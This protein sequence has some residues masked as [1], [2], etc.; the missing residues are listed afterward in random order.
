MLEQKQFAE[1]LFSQLRLN[2]LDP[3]DGFVDFCWKYYQETLKWSASINLTTNL[4]VDRFVSENIIDPYLAFS[5][6]SNMDHEKTGPHSILDIGCGGGYVGLV[7]HYLNKQK[8]A[9]FLLDSNRKKVNFCRSV[10]R[11]TSLI[12]CNTVNQEAKTY[13]SS[14]LSIKINTIVTRATMSPKDIL[15]LFQDVE[16]LDSQV[17]CFTTLKTYDAFASDNMTTKA[18]PGDPS[19]IIANSS[20]EQ[21]KIAPLFYEIKPTGLQRCLIVIRAK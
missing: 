17:V 1:T 6:F 9:L 15:L 12:N 13:L 18:P 5:C 16:L 7:W 11:N 3:D 10:I 21:R 4:S 8:G 14:A 20:K 2:D 19:F